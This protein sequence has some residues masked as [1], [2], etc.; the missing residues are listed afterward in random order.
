MHACPGN[1]IRMQPSESGLPS[2]PSMPSAT[3]TANAI[4]PNVYH[5]TT[6]RNDASPFT[7][8]TFVQ[9]QLDGSSWA[10]PLGIVM[11]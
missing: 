8:S 3:Y 5:P 1:Q 11:A 7:S 10:L 6:R 2:I 9:A 4:P